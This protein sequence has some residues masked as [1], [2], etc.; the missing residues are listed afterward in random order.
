MNIGGIKVGSVEIE[1]ACNL[2]PGIQETAAI[3]VTG[4][5]GGPAKLG[6]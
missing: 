5:H 4:P 1:R 6:R 3:A 2:V